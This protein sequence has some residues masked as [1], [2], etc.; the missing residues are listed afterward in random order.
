MGTDSA[1]S[2][3]VVE[4]PIDG[5]QLPDDFYEIEDV[6]EQCLCLKPLHMNTGFVSKAICRKTTCGFQLRTLTGKSI[7]NPSQSLEGKESTRLTPMLHKNF[8]ARK[9]KPL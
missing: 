9:E 2:E 1:T 7:L 5:N 8:Q 3:T 4:D 6:L